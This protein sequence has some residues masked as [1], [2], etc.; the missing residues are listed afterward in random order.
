MTQTQTIPKVRVVTIVH[1]VV[2]TEYQQKTLILRSDR[3]AIH[4]KRAA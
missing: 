4:T 1:Q 3:I 2:Q